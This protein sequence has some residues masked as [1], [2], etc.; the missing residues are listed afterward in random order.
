VVLSYDYW[1]TRYASSLDVLNQT[2][3]INDH[4]FVIVRVAARGF[5]SA[6]NGCDEEAAIQK[7]LACKPDATVESV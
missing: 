3:V 6:I 5:S 1:K 2:T 7:L 4:P